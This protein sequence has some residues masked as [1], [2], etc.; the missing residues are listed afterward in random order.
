[1]IQKHDSTHQLCLGR[2]P[3]GLIELVNTTT[4]EVSFS[5]VAPEGWEDVDILIN[6]QD[7]AMLSRPAGWLTTLRE[8][9]AKLLEDHRKASATRKRK[10]P[11]NGTGTTTTPRASKRKS[12]TAISA[13]TLTHLAGLPPDVAEKLRAAFNTATGHS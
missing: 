13:L 1:M 6:P 4:G 3:N 8:Q 7:V 10:E 2:R 12:P 9:R 11:T 5:V